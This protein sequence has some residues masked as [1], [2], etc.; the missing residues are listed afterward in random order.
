M[1]EKIL[2]ATHTG[3]LKFGNFDVAC[4]VL[5]DGTRVLSERGVIKVLGGKRGGAHWRRRKAD[6]DGANLPIYASANNIIP[7]INSDLMLALT[8]PIPYRAGGG[9]KA[10]GIKAK[11]LPEICDVWLR[12]RNGGKLHPSQEHIAVQAEIL[13]RAFA[14]V[15]ID[16]LVDEATGFQTLRDP[17]AL[18]FLV[19]QYIEEEKR[20]WQKE[21]P[22][23]FYINL[24]KIYNRNTNNIRHRP[25]YFAKFT[26][27]YIYFPME[28]GE[29]LRELDR[30]N[31]I[32]PTK[33]TRKERLHQH[34][35]KDYGR[36]KLQNQI[37]DVN[38]LLRLAPN[39]RRF[40]NLFARAFPLPGSQVEMDT[41]DDR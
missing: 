10:N 35:S 26:N 12:A 22:D 38:V 14:K 16:A 18:R 1:I 3:E 39:P 21:F 33:G 7:F 24:N 15:A 40:K 13:I 20:E 30:L 2:K 8:N 11:I 37:R 27:K 34:L 19:A 29:V 5:E 23:E 4:A 6:P 31:P 9:R 17:E 25:K 41:D 28:Q 32:D 36:I